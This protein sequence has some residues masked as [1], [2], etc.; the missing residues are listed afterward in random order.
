MSI[1]QK[2][3]Q[4]K[5]EEV[6]IL[7][8]R[9][10]LDNFKDF[11]FFNANL[12]SLKESLR[13]N[14]RLGII[15]EI[16]KASP[17]KG[18]LKNDFD[19]MEIANIY[20]QNK[21]DGISVLTDKKYFQG[22]IKFI[23]DIAQLKTVPLLRK[24]FIIDE[25]QVFESKAFGADAILLISEILSKDQINELTAAAKECSL[26]VLLEIHSE[27]QLNKINFI[28]NDLIGINNRDLDT[29]EINIGTALKLA[30]LIPDDVLIISE[31]GLNN[32]SD[33]KIVK[34]SKINGVL[35]GEHFMKSENIEEQLL[36]FIEWC[37]YE[38]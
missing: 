32:Y 34:S 33:I 8:S 15:A 6:K 27:A 13:H 37:K 22:N 17:S 9:Y 7:R 24:D 28:E 18:I 35:V 3:V 16:K 31:S 12:I 2:I 21:V 19:Y 4:T 10:S 11:E 1:L 36:E 23:A 26:E 5:K 14:H 38:S 25:F 20:I 29:F 30:N